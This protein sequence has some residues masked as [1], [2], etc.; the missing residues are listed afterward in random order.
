MAKS[1]PRKPTVPPRFEP[2]AKVRVKRGVIDPDFPDI[3]L[4]GWSG[5][6]KEVYQE[7]G[8]L[9][10]LIEWDQRTLRGIHPIYRKRCERDGLEFETM[11]LGE[12]EIEPDEGEPTPIEPPTAIRTQP[13]SEKDQDDRVR[14]A[15][16]LTHD[17]PLPEVSHQTLL[18]YH[19]YL[20]AHLKVPFKARSESDGRMLTVHRL[21]DPREY[22]LEEEYG[23]LC[24]ARDREGPFDVPLAELDEAGAG[25]RK[26]VGD[27]GYWFWNWR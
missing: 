14:M 22:D 18:A 27:Y 3:P 19:R 23:L 24:E 25:N 1:R 13:L 5:A 12:A 7:Q 9:T 20:A 2:G 11:G 8:E 6:I 26:L 16:G 10:Y 4:G 21:P 15:L 17:D